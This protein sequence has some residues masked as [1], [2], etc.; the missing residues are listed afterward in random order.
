M[1]GRERSERTRIT[2]QDIAERVGVSRATVSAALSGARYVSPDLK[3][4]IL[5]VVKELNYIPDFV[6]RSLKTN[7]TMTMGLVFPNILSPIWASI[8][9][10]VADIAR[11]A[12]FSTIMY[13]TDERHEVMQQALRTLQEKR[14]DGIVLA[15]CGECFTTLS[16]FITRVCIPTVLIDRSVDGL[17]LDTVVSDG[18]EGMY[19]AVN[20]LLDTGRRRIGLISLP[21]SISTGLERVSGYRSALVEH[22]LDIDESLIRVGGRGEEEGYGGAWE[23]LSTP[24]GHR[25]DAIV[26]ASH[27][28]TVGA[29][30]AIR[31]RGLRVPD[32]IAII[33]YDDTPWAPLLDPP[34]TVIHQP[35]YDMG[36]KAAEI[37]L[38]RLYE[39]APRNDEERPTDMPR[40]LVVLPTSVIYRGSCC[41]IHA[42]SSLEVVAEPLGTG[43]R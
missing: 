25:P 28:M 8:A 35:A 19:Q 13:D 36:A 41:R 32:D 29:M 11:Q 1:A 5:D 14:V 43:Q 18:K 12:G 30:K 39:D 20:H 10:G 23:L 42:R 26:A 16:D 31:D 15:H 4:Q 21:L 37:L 27:L 38:A 40:Q 2:Q 9:R 7:R 6:A 24:P 34:L 33:G 22:G 17:D 3:Q